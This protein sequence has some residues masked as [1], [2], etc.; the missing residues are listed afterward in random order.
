MVKLEKEQDTLLPTS[1]QGLADKLTEEMKLAETSNDL[2]HSSFVSGDEVDRLG[3]G[4]PG[5]ETTGVTDDQDETGLQMTTP[6]P[7]PHR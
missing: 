1:A 3:D 4:V 2:E 7:R 5:Y 6:V